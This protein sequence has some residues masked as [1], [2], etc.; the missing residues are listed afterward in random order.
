MS[1]KMYDILK[2]IALVG[3]YALATLVDGIGNIWSIPYTDQIVRTI[4][5]LGTVLGIV[6]GIS[7]VKYKKN[8]K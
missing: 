5:L 2:W 6:I 8:N 4:N 1:N 7:N 3:L